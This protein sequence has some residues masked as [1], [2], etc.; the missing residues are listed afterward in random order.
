MTTTKSGFTLYEISCQVLP[1]AESCQPL[2]E[3]FNADPDYQAMKA[4]WRVILGGG[5]NE[6]ARLAAV[7][8]YWDRV[9]GKVG[10]EGENQQTDEEYDL[11]KLDSD[12]L[13]T[14]LALIAKMKG[15]TNDD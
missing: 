15:E 7:K 12:E 13:K 9:R 3:P 8:E 14:F 2:P 5:K 11:S 4:L 10:A 6:N 1:W